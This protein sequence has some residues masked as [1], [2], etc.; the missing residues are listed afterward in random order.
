MIIII[1]RR[2]IAYLCL[3]M[4]NLIQ[5]ILVSVALKLSDKF[6]SFD[7]QSTVIS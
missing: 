2:T 6:Q 3:N 1:I 7:A 4:I 5:W